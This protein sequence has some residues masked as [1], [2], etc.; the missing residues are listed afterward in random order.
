MIRGQIKDDVTLGKIV[1]KRNDTDLN[2]LEV[3]AKKVQRP[4]A[5][6]IIYDRQAQRPIEVVS[7]SVTVH[8]TTL[9]R[10]TSRKI[11][12][13][14]LEKMRSGNFKRDKVPCDIVDFGGQRAFDTTHQLFIHHRGLILLMFNGSKDLNK[15]LNE[16]EENVTTICK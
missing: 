7:N 14:L 4:C 15:N 8:R 2:D 12:T 9:Q 5:R 1:N 16:Y 10:L 3:D 13:N 6:E 11:Q